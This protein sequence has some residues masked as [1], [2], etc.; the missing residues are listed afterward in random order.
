MSFNY[1]FDGDLDGLALSLWY[2]EVAAPL[3]A[4]EGA[5]IVAVTRVDGT[6]RVAYRVPP[7]RE[8]APPFDITNIEQLL[9]YGFV[10]A[11]VEEDI[12]APR[13][14]HV[15][16]LPAESGD[17]DG[18]MWSCLREWI[19]ELGPTDRYEPWEQDE[20]LSRS[21]MERVADSARRWSP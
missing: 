15:S 4:D 19:G 12:D 9:T 16:A 11:V 7:A 13:A 20:D 3:L 17:N 21:L 14:L 6:L 18:V 2:R 5:R 10:R 8:F 1:D